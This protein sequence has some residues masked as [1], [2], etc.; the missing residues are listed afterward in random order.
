MRILGSIS[1][2][3]LRAVQTIEFGKVIRPLGCYKIQA[4]FLD[5]WGVDEIVLLDIDSRF[6]LNAVSEVAKMI[7][8]PLCYGGGIENLEQ[9]VEA[10]RAGADRVCLNSLLRSNPSEVKRIVNT[11]GSQCIV[12]SI[13]A[14]PGEC[15]K[16]QVEKATEL[17]VGEVL[18]RS[19]SND[20]TRSGLDIA[21]AQ[22]AIASTDLPVLIAG[23][24]GGVE[25]L[26]NLPPVSGVVIGNL[27]SHK[28]HA[29][30]ILKSAL[31]NTR[32]ESQANYLSH[33]VGV[34]LKLEMPEESY[35]DSISFSH[36]KDE[37]I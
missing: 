18:V 25:H 11:L 35:L 15:I 19:K 2:Q 21:L 3:G 28:E 33:K 9:A 32:K 8:T 26:V 23:G 10:V 22:A 1:V 4:E 34:G 14:T 20:G 27:F 16:S 37:V 7:S 13:D 12:A 29:V 17:G 5:R 24:A 36:F 6:N 30:Q 31:A